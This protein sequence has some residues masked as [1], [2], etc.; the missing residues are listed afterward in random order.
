[1][2]ARICFADIET[3]CE[4]ILTLAKGSLMLRS[5]DDGLCSATSVSIFRVFGNID[6]NYEAIIC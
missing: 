4:P 2:Q 3:W 5:L 6:N 1:M